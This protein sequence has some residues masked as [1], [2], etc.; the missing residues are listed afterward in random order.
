MNI[1]IYDNLVDYYVRQTL[2]IFCS[3][4]SFNLGWEDSEESTK[5]NIKNIHSSWSLKDYIASGLEPYIKKAFSQSKTFKYDDS[6]ISQIELNL[7][8]S[9]DIHFTHTH[10]NKIVALYYVNLDWK[11]G[12]YGETIF[13]DNKDLKNIKYTSK[14]IPGRIILFDGSVPHSIRPQ[15]S[16]APKFRFSISIFFQK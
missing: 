16:I 4:S 15:S 9:D 11:D 13:Y 7:V 6:K 5:E 8:K 3:N 10:N 1:E 14:Y 2:E 12:Y